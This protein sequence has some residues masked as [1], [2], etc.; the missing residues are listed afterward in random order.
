MTRLVRFVSCRAP[1]WATSLLALALTLAGI[2]CGPPPGPVGPT[3]AVVAAAPC[4]AGAT[5]RKVLLTGED[6]E[7]GAAKLAAFLRES[8][9][10]VLQQQKGFVKVNYKGM[11]IFML[12]KIYASPTR[13][14]RIVITRFFAPKD[15]IR[16]KPEMRE[17]AAMLND[18]LNVAQFRIDNDG[19]LA[20]TG[21][22]TFMDELS[23]EL[24]EGY[25]NWLQ[26]FVPLMLQ[27]VPEVRNYLK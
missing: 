6:D 9:M 2:G 18:K 21:A 27:T 20:V 16:G 24:I 3:P 14:D 5:G 15:E 8:G 7:V 17:L 10:E 12:P 13:V 22:M 26:G 23:L 19:D 11:I 1:R 25:L 4:P